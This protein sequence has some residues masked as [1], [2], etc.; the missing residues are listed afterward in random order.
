MPCFPTASCTISS[1]RGLAHSW[2]III[3]ITTTIPAS[4]LLPTAVQV[5]SQAFPSTSS[6]LDNLEANFCMWK[7]AE[8]EIAAVLA[9]QVNVLGDGI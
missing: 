8:A 5:F 2:L 4:P 3:T 1:H 9:A 6:M 7:G